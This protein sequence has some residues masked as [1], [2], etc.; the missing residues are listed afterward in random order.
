MPVMTNALITNAG[1]LG[2]GDNSSVANVIDGAQYGFGNHLPNIDAATP[3]IMRP[4]V[5]IIVHAPTMFQN[6]PNMSD[7]LKALVERHATRIENIDPQYTIETSTVPSGNDGQELNMP[8]NARRAQLSP[9]MTFPELTGNLVWNFFRQWLRMIKDPDTQASSLAGI[10]PSGSAISQQVMS[11]FTMDMLF[12]Q[13]DN[14][15]RPE[16][17]IDAY[18][19]SQMWPYDIGPAGF[20]KQL[21]VSER[22][23]RTISFY[24][25]LQHNRN[26]RA[27]GQQIAEVLQLHL[28]NYDYA[29]PVALDIES[30]IQDEGLQYEVSQLSN[31]F[32]PV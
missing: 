10:V 13:Y 16:N 24:G 7:V 14:T 23:D 27:V 11:S 6:V 20:T 8:T 17:I 26:T 32:A 30:A 25:V 21:G 2:T 1:L 3:L 15:L 29:T 9:T 28:I 31:T 18:F 4:I 19:I 12:I 5:P 22:P